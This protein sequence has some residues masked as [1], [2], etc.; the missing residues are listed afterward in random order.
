MGRAF[1]YRRAAK[2]KRWAKMSAVFPKLSKAI[3]FAAR[4]G[5]PDPNLNPL[6]RMAI[7]NAKKENMPKDNIDSA[8]KRA[9]DKDAQGL[10]EVRYEGYGPH[11][12]AFLV[13]STT[14][15]TNR[16]VA[17]LRT[18]FGRCGGSLGKSGTVEHLFTRQ[19]V[20]R[21]PAAGQDIETL[22]LELIDHG[23]EE[24]IPEEDEIVLLVAFENFG[25]MQKGLEAKGIAIEKAEVQWFPNMTTEV[26]PEQ[27]ADV[28][29][30]LGKLDEDDDVQAVYTTMA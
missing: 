19:G 20:F 13:E 27:Q 26:T 30:L 12:I 8:I 3:T 5:G 14:D 16:T 22:E 9:I 10:E 17:N 4:N 15:N 7:Q 11:G 6:L 28:E 2:E 23:L 24:L 18:H 1:E 29:K 25:E 21:I